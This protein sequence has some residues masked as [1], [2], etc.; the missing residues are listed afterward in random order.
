MGPFRCLATMI[1]AMWRGYSCPWV[2]LLPLL[3]GGVDV[4]P[5]DEHHHVGILLDAA[6]VPQVGEPGA[7]VRP[8]L[9]HPVSTESRR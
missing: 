7:V 5:V 8:V 1:S 2:G 6:A 4:L 9:N 3:L